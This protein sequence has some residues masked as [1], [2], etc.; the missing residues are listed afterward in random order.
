MI[1]VVAPGFAKN[2][3]KFVA[4]ASNGRAD[5]IRLTRANKLFYKENTAKPVKYGISPSISL[6]LRRI[7]A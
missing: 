6:L 2:H 3:L 7:Y 1:T 4:S 5:Y